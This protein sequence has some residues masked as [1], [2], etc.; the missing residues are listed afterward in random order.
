[1][2]TMTFDE[3]IISGYIDTINNFKLIQE[4]KNLEKRAKILDEK[5]KKSEKIEE[6]D[7]KELREIVRQLKS[8]N[9]N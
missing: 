6:D 1:E 2:E 4:R 3:K 5:I 8:Q 7:L 9:I